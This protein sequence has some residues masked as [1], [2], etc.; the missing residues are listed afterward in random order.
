LPEPATVAAPESK[1]AKRANGVSYKEY[2]RL[3]AV[4]YGGEGERAAALET[5]TG[6]ASFDP[7]AED[8]QPAEPSQL[9]PQEEEDDEMVGLD[10][11]PRPHAARAPDT[12]RREPVSL[13]A[14]GRRVRAVRRPAAEKSYNPRFDDWAARL[15]REGAKEVEAERRRL[16]IEAEAQARLDLAEK[17][18]AEEED[19]ERERQKK[20]E[21][22]EDVEEDEAEAESEWEGIVSEA[23]GKAPEWLLKKRPAR[24]TQAQR[25]RI[26]RRKEEERRLQAV[27]REKAKAQQAIRIAALAKEVRR[28]ERE[29]EEALAALPS[30]A[31]STDDEGEVVLRR[32]QF[33]KAR[34]VLLSLIRLA[35]G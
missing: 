1:R 35:H 33:G 19:R 10:F 3:R 8:D 7:W 34:W 20:I 24:K 32:R 26:V 21:A 30:P 18:Q 22:G 27:A 9:Q 2:H 12:L 14:D 29:K 28:H 4:A 13:T 17:A 5:R 16:E 15:E 25:N 11:V 31:D 6:D 23:E